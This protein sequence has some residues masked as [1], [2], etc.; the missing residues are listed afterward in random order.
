MEGQLKHSSTTFAMHHARERGWL[1]S[2]SSAEALPDAAAAR[3][4]PLALL[5]KRSADPSSEFN[6]GRRRR[7]AVHEDTAPALQQVVDAPRAV[8][9]VQQ[10]AMDDAAVTVPLPQSVFPSAADEPTPTLPSTGANPLL[11]LD[12]PSTIPRVPAKSKSFFSNFLPSL[13]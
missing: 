3:T 5:V 8:S 13:F 6:G 7:R 2:P 10:Q 11:F 1:G 12:V 9:P 4:S